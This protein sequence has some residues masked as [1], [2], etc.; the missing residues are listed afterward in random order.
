[1]RHPSLRAAWRAAFA[2]LALAPTSQAEAPPGIRPGHPADGMAPA[3]MAPAR[4]GDVA[5]RQELDA[6]R[7]AGA[8]AAYDLFIARHG[9]HPL[10]RTARIERSRLPRTPR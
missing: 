7:R 5:I 8:R 9:N 4:N 2:W 10:A 6:A 1:M 3:A